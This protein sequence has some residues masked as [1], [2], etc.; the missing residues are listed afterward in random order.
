MSVCVY[1]SVAISP[2][3]GWGQTNATDKRLECRRGF[4]KTHKKKKKKRQKEEKILTPVAE[5]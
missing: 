2:L 1:R 3:G 5:G 4:A